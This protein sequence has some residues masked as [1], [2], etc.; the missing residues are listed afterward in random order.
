[1]IPP[2]LQSFRVVFGAT[3]GS[4]KPPPWAIISQRFAPSYRSWPIH[5][6]VANVPDGDCGFRSLTRAASVSSLGQASAQALIGQSPLPA[7]GSCILQFTVWL[8][9]RTMATAVS[10]R[11]SRATSVSSLGSGECSGLIGQS[12]LPA[13][14]TTRSG[15]LNGRIAWRRA[16]APALMSRA[17]TRL[18]SIASMSA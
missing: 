5:R 7:P 12:P 10:G 16:S 11:W 2:L 18:R 4:A 14:A 3:Q 1:V 9:T 15:R 8:R 17:I 6:L 13:H